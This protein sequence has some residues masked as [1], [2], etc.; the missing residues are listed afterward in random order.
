M[1][2]SHKHKFIFIRVRKT[3]STSMHVALADVCGEFDIITEVDRK[4]DLDFLPHKVK[5]SHNFRGSLF[6]NHITGLEIQNKIDSKIW[7]TYFKFCFE[8][9]PWDRS[10]SCFYD[11][12]QKGPWDREMLHKFIM[13][14]GGA[15]ANYSNWH[16]YTDRNQKNI[17]VDKVFK[18]E[19]L[20]K[21]LKEIQTRIKLTTEIKLPDFRYKER[22]RKDFI[23][24]RDVLTNEEKERISEI[25]HR[26]IKEFGYK[27]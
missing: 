17:I 3:A 25:F 13:K 27:W 22:F 21:S 16:Y 5:H 11:A 1:I 26:E 2:I 19:E 23:N 24:Y 14:R 12:H 18:Y 10:I 7:N 4:R 6:Y 9:N 8:R 15:L 20:D